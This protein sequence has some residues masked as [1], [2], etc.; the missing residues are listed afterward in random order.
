MVIFEI[1]NKTM[2]LNFVSVEDTEIYIDIFFLIKIIYGFCSIE[3][4][5]Y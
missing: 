4:N 3:R 1:A 2:V 5:K